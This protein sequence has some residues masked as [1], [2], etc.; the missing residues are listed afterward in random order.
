MIYLCVHLHNTVQLRNYEKEIKELCLRADICWPKLQRPGFNPA[1]VNVGFV[2]DTLALGYAFFQMLPFSPITL[3]PSM[4][5]IHL[6]IC[7]QCNLSN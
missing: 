1:S 4:L 5:H 7:H 3:I 6:T 2:M